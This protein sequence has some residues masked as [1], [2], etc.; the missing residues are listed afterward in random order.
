[1]ALWEPGQAARRREIGAASL[2]LATASRDPMATAEALAWRI[3]DHLEL[4][5]MPVVHD[6]PRRYRELAAA[7]RLPW[8]RWHVTVVEGALAQLAGRLVDAGTLA[9]RAVGLMAPSRRNNVAAFFRLQSFMIRL[10]ERRPEEREPLVA[11]TAEHEMNRPIWRATVALTHALLGR[12]EATQEV[13]ADLAMAKFADLPW[14]GSTL[15]TYARLA[16]ACA[17]I[18][19]PRF[20]EPL[21]SLLEP[22][23]DT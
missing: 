22:Y 5:D 15:A 14:D 3:L 21:R 20:A 19:S 8:V 23:V 17:L 1:Y 10:E 6:T 4:G 16:E 7:C 13:L 2:E 12:T 11:K 18:D 9:R